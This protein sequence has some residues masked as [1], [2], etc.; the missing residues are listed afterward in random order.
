MCVDADPELAA[1][2]AGARNV[3]D[4]RQLV[5]DEAEDRG[6][7]QDGNDRPD[8]LEPRVRMNLRALRAARSTAPAVTD[9]K[10]QQRAF[11]DDEDRSGIDGDPLVSVVDAHRVRRMRCCRCKAGIARVGDGNE[12]QRGAESKD[13]DK[14]LAPHRQW[15]PTVDGGLTRAA[16]G[17][18]RRSLR[19]VLARGPAAARPRL[20]PDR[21]RARVPPR[22]CP[23][24]TA[25]ADP[26]A[27]Y[28]ARDL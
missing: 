5:E 22:P 14:S 16:T 10:P 21:G 18:G 1:L 4:P 6:E 8:Q 3:L 17:P 20:R 15:H 13:E 28:A 23:G 19:R 2:C 27:L 9:H 24:G 7:D 26:L 25:R 11:D 12:R